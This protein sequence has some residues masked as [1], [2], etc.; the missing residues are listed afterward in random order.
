M[1]K[2][3]VLQLLPSLNYGGS[4]TMI[5]VIYKVMNKENVLFDFIIDHSELL[6]M[7]P[8][9]EDLG[10]K[11]YTMPSFKGYNIMEI[12]KA[13]NDFFL[14]HNDYDIIHIHIR[15]YAS[16]I[17]PIARKHGIKTV[18]HS[19]NTSNGKGPFVFVKDLLQLP[20]RYQCDYYLA[21]SLEAG[22]WLFGDRIV[23]SDR[24][25]VLKSGIDT[26]RY[27][28]DEKIRKEY[29]KSFKLKDELVLVQAGRFTYQKNYPFTVDLFNS[30]LKHNNNA[31][32]F[33]IGVGETR[34]EI[35]DKVD[36][37]GINDYVTFLEARDDLNNIY[38]MADIFLMPSHYEGISLAALEAQSTGIKCLFSQNIDP[39]TGITDVCHFL[40]LDENVW[41]DNMYRDDK[42]TNKKKQIIAAGYDV[43]DSA[44]WLEDFYKNI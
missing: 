8:I 44:K 11:I 33:L 18:I 7:K 43:C 24:F 26:D 2:I 35:M 15:S 10:C 32:L 40:P 14:E 30:F 6:E 39:K 29:R 38:Q 25:H 9:V 41:I 17:V 31:R 42:R 37:F 12:R 3:K 16:I 21:C 34:K 1:K 27:T 23:N 22:Q 20:L 13:W 4:Q 19:Q 36:E 28:Y 5:V